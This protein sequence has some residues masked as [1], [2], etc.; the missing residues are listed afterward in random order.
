MWSLW[1]RRWTI[2]AGYDFSSFPTK[3][4]LRNWEKVTSRNQMPGFSK[5]PGISTPDSGINSFPVPQQKHLF[6]RSQTPVWERHVMKLRFASILE[7]L[8]HQQIVKQSFRK[9]HYEAGASSFLF[10]QTSKFEFRSFQPLPGPGR[11]NHSPRLQ[12][13]GD[14]SKIPIAPERRQKRSVAAP[15]LFNMLVSAYPRLKFWAIIES[16][17]QGLPR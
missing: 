8:K 1:D 11:L 4:Q 7:S 6:S 17:Y 15:G 2:S 5:K 16:P 12:P 9:M 13:W 3:P 14:D 10:Q